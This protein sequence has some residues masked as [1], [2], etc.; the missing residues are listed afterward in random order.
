M[1]D[2]MIA[3]GRRAVACKGWKWKAGMRARGCGDSGVVT[4]VWSDPDTHQTTDIFVSY[5]E[6]CRSCEHAAPD[7]DQ[8]LP[9]LSDPATVGCLLAL[10]RE[11]WGTAII[12][13]YL[14]DEGLWETMWEGATAAGWC[15]RGDTEA[16]AL[17]AALESAP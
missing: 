4:T 1:T 8:C 3:L 2:E 16:E 5:D 10:V 14:Y 15:G 11:A 9:D 6:E 13:S 7:Y 17:V 12:V